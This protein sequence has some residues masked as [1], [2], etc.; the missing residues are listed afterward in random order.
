MVFRRNICILL[1]FFFFLP[2]VGVAGAAN[3]NPRIDALVRNGNAYSKQGNHVVALQL[4]D[5]AIRMSPGDLDL[6]YKRAKVHGDAGHYINAIKD[7]NQVINQGKGR[8]GH[9]VR[10]RADCFMALGY[11]QKAADDYQAFLR[12]APKDGKVWSYLAE[13][14]ALMGQKQR[15]LQA[16]NMGIATNSHW[17][18]KLKKLRM[19]IMTGQK[20]TPHKPF[21]N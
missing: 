20:L 16:V 4:Y 18:G 9:A 7:L 8:Y 14:Y 12:N 21:S 15:A 2:L 3:G 10:F 13:T 17:S 19:Q 1:M 6:Y 5:Q 11:Y